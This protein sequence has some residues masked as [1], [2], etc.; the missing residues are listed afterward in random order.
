MHIKRFLL[1]VVFLVG[2]F[3]FGFGLRTLQTPSAATALPD[4]QKNF[5]VIVINRTTEPRSLQSVWLVSLDRDHAF[6]DFF[7]IY[8]FAVDQVTKELENNPDLADSLQFD[9]NGI[10][11]GAFFD[12]VRRNHDIDWDGYIL[13][14]E[15]GVI[16]F[17]DEIG[18]VNVQGKDF[19]G[20]SFVIN[21]PEAGENASLAYVFQKNLIESFCLALDKARFDAAGF[22]RLIENGGDHFQ[23]D[24]PLSELLEYFDLTLKSDGTCTVMDQI[25]APEA[26]HSQ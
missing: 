24:I 20:R 17:V 15:I 9:K 18:G 10:L 8:P 14:D 19:E 3:L 25:A 2:G 21:R 4:Q 1:V 7:P 13:I 5:L 22:R 16:S 26:D 23:T 6:L 12:E 11:N